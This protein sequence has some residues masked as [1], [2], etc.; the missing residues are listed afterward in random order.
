MIDRYTR[1]DMRVLWSDQNRYETW[2]EVELAVCRAME[3]VGSVPKGTADKVR[4]N[5]SIDPE[6]I[7]EIE[8]EVRH[9]V[10]AFLTHIEEQAGPPARWLHLGL[11]SSDVLDTAFALQLKQAG[12]ILLGRLDRLAEVLEAQAKESKDY[13]MVGRTHGIFAEPTSAGLV[14]AGF[15]AEI[16]RARGRLSNATETIRYGKI[17][18]TVGNYGNVSP[19]IEAA[20]LAELDLHVE[21]VATQIV[22]RDRHA[23]FFCALGQTAASLE[24][25]ATQ[26][27]HW[28]R[29]EVGEAFEPF[30]RDQKGSSAMPHKRNPIL[31]ENVCGLA[32]IIRSHVAAALENVALWHERDI[33]HSSV[34]RVIAPDATGLLDL[35]CTALQKLS[36]GLS[37]IL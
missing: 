34:E 26:V 36:K 31:S 32:R 9:D 35:C 11:T 10:I 21:P 25:I 19:E 17:A 24:R 2:L 16:K 15:Y 6:R 5:S 29:S 4:L 27:R 12:A 22:P 30:G 3:D 18:G 13:A 8:R 23:E 33:S 1:T 7:V 14:F 37:C 20:A 28:Q